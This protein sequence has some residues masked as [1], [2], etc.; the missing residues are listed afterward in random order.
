MESPGAKELMSRLCQKE[1]NQ[2]LQGKTILLIN[3]E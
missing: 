1:L 3:F 2:M